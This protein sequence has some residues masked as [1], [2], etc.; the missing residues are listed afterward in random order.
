MKRTDSFD[1]V[2]KKGTQERYQL[3]KPNPYS[4]LLNV[5]TSGSNDANGEN[6]QM[7][8]LGQNQTTLGGDGAPK[9]KPIDKASLYKKVPPTLFSNEDGNLKFVAMVVKHPCKVLVLIFGICIVITAL[10]FGALKESPITDDTHAYDLS[11]IRSIKYDSLLLTR[12]V[13]FNTDKINTNPA[14]GGRRGKPKN[15]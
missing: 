1:R 2:L 8:P 6:Y 4:F 11:D 5:M 3:T 15:S 14:R 12:D 7:V 9:R 13:V 10:L